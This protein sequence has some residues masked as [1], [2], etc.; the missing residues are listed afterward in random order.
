MPLGLKRGTVQ[1]VL[2]DIQWEENASQTIKK[3]KMIL[4]DAAIDIQHIGSTSIKNI[5]SKPIIDIVVGVENFEKILEYNEKLQCEGIIYRGSD[6][7]RQL[8]YV[9]GDIEKDTRTH[10]IHVVKYNGAEWNNY[11]YFRDYLNENNDVALEYQ[12]LKEELED[13]YSNDRVAY[14]EGKQ[15]FIDRILS[16][17]KI[18]ILEPFRDSGIEKIRQVLK[19]SFTIKQLSNDADLEEVKSELK[20]AEI[21][22][23]QPSLELLHNYEID[24]PKLKMIQMT[25]AGTDIYTRSSL[26]FP[27]DK[28]ILTNASGTYG[29]VMSQFVIGMILSV[30]L[31]FK[32]YTMQQKA[33]IWEKR[34]PIKSL[35]HARVLIYGAGDIGSAIAKRLTGFDAYCIGVCRNTA[36]DREYFDE[37]CT[38]EDSEKYLPDVDVVIG[39]IPNSRETEEYMNYRRL[40]AMK[41]GAI[42]VNVGRGNFIDCMALDDVLRSNHLWGAALDVT[43]P[44]PLPGNHSLWNNPKCM[45]TPHASGTTFKHLDATEN[46]LC[47]IVCDNLSRYCDGTEI[48]NRVY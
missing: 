2:H 33:K 18:L 31:N 22:I 6:V 1:L 5:K 13:K 12:R 30:M 17:R 34:G 10:H 46:L 35:D 44:E 14:T 7:D 25:W 20:E 42:I 48:R 15:R 24:C 19:E 40:N 26:P 23:G 4:G 9:V 21:I 11:I 41:E 39:C 47:D 29:M 8:L 27:K 38:L 43:N 16:R 3:I 45:I 36:K 37:L 28:V 32:D